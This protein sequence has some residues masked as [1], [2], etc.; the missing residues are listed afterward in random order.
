MVLCPQSLLF[1]CLKK[2]KKKEIGNENGLARTIL[3]WVNVVGW[4]KK[5]K[6][7]VK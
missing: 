7:Y 3:N 1:C 4:F 5:T 6:Y 2:K